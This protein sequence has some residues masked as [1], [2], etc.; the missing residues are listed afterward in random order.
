MN[1]NHGSFWP[2]IIILT[3]IGY[4][5]FNLKIIPITPWQAFVTY[6]PAILIIAG[7]KNIL[8]GSARSPQRQDG[9]IGL[10]FVLILLGAY[11]LAPRLGFSVIPISWSLIWPVLLIIFGFS[12]LFKKGNIVKVELNGVSY[13]KSPKTT[14]SLI[15]EVRRGSTGWALDDTYIRH[16]IGSV[17][18]DLTQAI[19]PEREVVIDVG[20]MVGEVVIY[21]PP[22]LPVKIDCQLDMGDMVVFD[23]AES[24]THRRLELQSENYQTAVKKLDIRVRWRIGEIKIR[25]IG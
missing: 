23:Q 21:L 4:L 1:T 19:I 22:E 3:G 10:N 9:D 20:G 24:G 8:Q 14:S 5:L 7:L 2:L 12:L 16:G 17:H 18:L 11:L 15:G 13:E 6:W 25:R